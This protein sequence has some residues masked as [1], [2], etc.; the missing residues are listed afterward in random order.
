MGADALAPYITSA[1][2]KS[3]SLVAIRTTQGGWLGRPSQSWVTRHYKCGD[4]DKT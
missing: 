4:S 1:F 3:K 2:E